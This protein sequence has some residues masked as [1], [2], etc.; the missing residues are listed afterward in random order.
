MVISDFQTIDENKGKFAA[1][2]PATLYN[3]LDETIV[4]RKKTGLETSMISFVLPRKT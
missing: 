3:I 2:N 4:Y 1:L